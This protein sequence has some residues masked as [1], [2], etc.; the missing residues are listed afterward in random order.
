MKIRTL[1]LLPML[2]IALVRSFAAAIPAAQWAHEKSDVPVDPAVTWGRFENGMRYAILPNAIPENHVSIRLLVKAGSIDE[3]DAQCGLAYFVARMGFRGTRSFSAEELARYQQEIGMKPGP[4]SAL[5]VGFDLTVYKLELPKTDHVSLEKALRVLRDFADGIG[6]SA[7]ALGNERSVIL[8]RKRE[9]DTVEFRATKD[10]WEFLMPGALLPRR[11]PDG[12]EEVIR[13]APPAE[14][15]DFYSTWYRPERMAVIVVG[16]VQTAEVAGLIATAFG[17]LRARGPARPEPDLGHVIAPQTIATHLHTDP[18]DH[19]TRVS[20]QSI[21]PYSSEPDTVANRLK[22]LPR[23]LGYAMLNRRLESLS[24]QGER[25]TMLAVARTDELLSFARVSSVDIW[26]DR[27]EKWRPTLALAEQELRRALVHGFQAE[28]LRQVTALSAKGRAEAAA[29]ASARRSDRLADELSQV[30][31]Y[32]RVFTHPAAIRD[33]MKPALEK[34]TV[35]DCQEA[36]RAVWAEPGRSV[37]VAGNLELANPVAEL[38]A[39]YTES[40]GVAVAAP[41]KVESPIWGYT[42]F[43]AAG[44]IA[45]RRELIDLGITEVEFKNGV[46]LNLKPTDFELATVLAGVRI[47]GGLLTLPK[48]KPGLQAFAM[49][50]GN[51]MGLGKH[52]AE[53]LRRIFLGRSVDAKFTVGTD[54]FLLSGKT[55]SA[56][57]ELELQLLA[58]QV[59]DPGYRPEAEA[60]AKKDVEEAYLQLLHKPE[61]LWLL[62]IDR[63]L[64]SGD[65]RFGL[66]D[67]QTID[68]YAMAD[69]RAWLAPQL[70]G[71]PIELSLVGDFD[72]DTAIA[73]TAKTFG[74]LPRRATKPPYSEERRISFPPAGSSQTRNVKTASL[75]GLLFL[76]WP[77][78]DAQDL[79]RMRQLNMLAAIIEGR[80]RAKFGNDAAGAFEPRATS[81]ASDTFTGFGYLQAQMGVNPARGAEVLAAVR[82]IIADLQKN[83]VAADELGQAKEAILALIAKSTRTNEYWLNAVGSAQGYP[84]RLDWCRNP[85]GVVSAISRVEVSSLAARYLTGSREISYLALPDRL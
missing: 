72:I 32:D 71:A 19:R 15:A 30:L 80:L 58:A 34:V 37:F 28:E 36:L 43:G 14:F 52:S 67:I 13:N 10:D 2:V 25:R 9:R 22:Y 20:I 41:A 82:E 74:A 55:T 11:F 59:S 64:A 70:A 27:A 5:G 83:G 81:V 39:A 12:R 75:R 66:P 50:A 8:A 78:D 56:D 84:Q 17:D 51:A 38:A 23:E 53:D 1:I 85:T 45:S 31:A 16:Q 68:R 33:M 26:I 24:G 29:R 7:D 61:G 79:A 60:K 48:D 47:G 46:R 69:L 6:F 77:T 62:E 21:E 44:E 63:F 49:A 65:P 73:L 35:A 4:D 57:L 40:R 3:T 54:S 18:E 42:D 76:F